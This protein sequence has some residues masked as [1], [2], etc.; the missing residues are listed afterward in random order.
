MYVFNWKVVWDE[1]FISMRLFKNL[2]DCVLI[3]A[4]A[5]MEENK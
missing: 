4:K 1:D 2:L 3:H 5:K